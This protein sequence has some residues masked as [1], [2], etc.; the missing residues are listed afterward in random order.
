MMRENDLRLTGTSANFRGL[1]VL[2]H[3]IIDPQEIHFTKIAHTKL[4][5]LAIL[6]EI[7]FGSWLKEN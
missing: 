6:I 3:P 1:A 4:E 2:R 7:Y 5:L